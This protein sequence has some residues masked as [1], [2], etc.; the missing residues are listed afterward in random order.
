[1]LMC[2]IEK[3]KLREELIKV[4]VVGSWVEIAISMP[5]EMVSAQI[6]AFSIF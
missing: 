5:R 1:M 3:S 6:T 4:G 2:Y